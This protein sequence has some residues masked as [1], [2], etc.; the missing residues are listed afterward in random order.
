MLDHGSR[1]ISPGGG[2]TYTVQGPVCVLFD[3][4]ELPWPCC[5]LVWRGKQPSWNRIGKRFIP[6]LAAQR[7]PSYS[8]KGVDVWGIE[9]EQVLTVYYQRLSPGEKQWWYFKGPSSQK[10][11]DYVIL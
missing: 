4:E 11:P 10:P 6:D 2:F 3:R 8:V 1:I 5:S 9:W 7:C